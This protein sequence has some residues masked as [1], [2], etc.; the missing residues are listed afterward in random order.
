M[1]NW[2]LLF[3]IE[4]YIFDILDQC[5]ELEFENNNEAALEKIKEG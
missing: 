2:K 1:V 5:D 3:Y 4:E